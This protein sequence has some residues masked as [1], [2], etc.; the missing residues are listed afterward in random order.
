MIYLRYEKIIFVRHGQSEYNLLKIY[1]GSIDTP[2]TELGKQQAKQTGELLRDKNITYIISSN[3]SRAY[4]TA[5]TIKSVI[6][7]DNTIELE[8][9]P[10]LHEVNFGDVQG[11]PYLPD[12][13]GLAYG[14][15]SGTGES[16]KELYQRAEKALEHITSINT[17]GNI[18]VVGHGS[19]ASVLFAYTEGKSKDDLIEYKRQWSF[20]N[21]EVKEKEL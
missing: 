15:E 12:T 9:T 4:D 8:S 10:L 3:L 5:L 13:T 19:F 6:D 7:P 14:I 21:G 2:L 16:K 11:K 1:S 18:L 17:D 20:G